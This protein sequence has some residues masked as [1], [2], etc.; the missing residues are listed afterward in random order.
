M[1]L[2]RKID[3]AGVEKKPFIMIMN[4][5]H[6]PSMHEALSS[7]FRTHTLQTVVNTH[8]EAFTTGNTFPEPEGCVG[9]N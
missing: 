2:A 7:I 4:V 1:H 8:M 5:E 6:L 9:R 3:T